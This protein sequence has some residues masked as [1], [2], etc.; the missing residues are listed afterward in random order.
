MEEI[1]K[2]I[3]TELNFIR[4]AIVSLDFIL[5]CILFFKRMH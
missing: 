1:L 3:I 4:V 2:E 5:I